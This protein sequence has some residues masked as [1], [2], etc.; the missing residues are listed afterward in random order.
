MVLVSDEEFESSRSERSRES[1]RRVRS[2]KERDP[3]R[4]AP[5][6]TLPPS[7]A[8]AQ[9]SPPGGALMSAGDVGNILKSYMG[10]QFTKSHETQQ[11]VLVAMGV[12]DARR[13]VHSQQ[14]KSTS[15]Q[16]DELF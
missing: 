8:P 6:R 2:R 9:L 14:I 12:H 16:F 11:E 3:N 15:A 13:V 4:S 7:P 10:E 5:S 1:P